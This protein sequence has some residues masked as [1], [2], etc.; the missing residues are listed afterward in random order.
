[1]ETAGSPLGRT[2]HA[3]RD[4]LAPTDVGLFS[5]G[6]R[7]ARGLRREELA[8]LA[9]LSVDYLVRIEQGRASNPSPQ[10]VESPTRAL[11]LDAAERD[12]LYRLSG[13]QPP[14][15]SAVSTHIPPG[16]RVWWPDSETLRSPSS[17]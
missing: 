3:W 9:G 6:R 7:R 15:T 10:I 5:A 12:H 13:L 16:V 2:L 14:A 11:Q 1:M 8:A 17:R 4:R